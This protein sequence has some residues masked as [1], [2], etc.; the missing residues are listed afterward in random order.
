MARCTT[1]PQVNL[2]TKCDRIV[3]PLVKPLVDQELE[4]SSGI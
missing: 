1:W 2:E 3:R 4:S